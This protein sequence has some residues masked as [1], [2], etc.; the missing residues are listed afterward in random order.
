MSIR[1]HSLFQAILARISFGAVP[2]DGIHWFDPR[3]AAAPKP[4]PRA[5]ADE[6]PFDEGRPDADWSPISLSLTRQLPRM[7]RK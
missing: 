5:L 2:V 1:S 6:P 3:E 4:R 7:Q